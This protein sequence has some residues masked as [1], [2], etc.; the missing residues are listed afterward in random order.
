MEN[1]LNSWKESLNNQIDFYEKSS[2][3]SRIDNDFDWKW[4]SKAEGIR[5]LVKR[6]A[7]LI[8]RYLRLI[9]GL[10]V[11]HSYSKLWFNNNACA[12]FETREA[13]EDGLSKIIFDNHLILKAVHHSKF[14]FSKTNYDDLFEIIGE[15]LFESKDLPNE[16][17]GIQMKEFTISIAGTNLKI[18]GSK[19][20]I[21]LINH[22]RQYFVERDGLFLGPRVDDIVF[23]CGACIG[24]ISTVFAAIVGSKGKVH[25]FDPIPLHSKFIKLHSD[26][27]EKLSGIII[28]NELAVDY[29]SSSSRGNIT[30]TK[31]ISPGGLSVDSYNSISLDEY[32]EKNKLTK[33]DYIKMDIEGYEIQALKGAANIIKLHKPRL[34]ICCYHKP[35]DLWEIPRLLKKLNP[36]YK[37]YFGHHTPVAFESVFYAS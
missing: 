8:Y 19:L 26:L 31:I 24:E 14:Y 20:N 33:V 13:L 21:D 10:G 11:M 36:D 1:K 23:D 16:Y 25:T 9:N 30:D 34:A 7:P 37:I 3:R 5:G 15:R 4:W 12:L 28:I 32:F 2:N 35:E 6:N 17:G 22:Y 29:K 27:N 18:I